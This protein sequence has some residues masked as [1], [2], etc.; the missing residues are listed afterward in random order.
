MSLVTMK[1]LLQHAKENGYAVGSFNM[2]SIETVRGAIRAAEKLNSPIIIQFAQVHTSIVPME[3]IAPVMLEAAR[4]ATVPV[5]VHFDHGTDY[6]EV[7]RA[8]S[9]G[10]TSVMFDAASYPFEKNVSLTKKAVDLAH[11]KGASIE[12]ELGQVGG[13]EG[14]LVVDK[15][16]LTDVKE[17]VEFVERTGVDAL[18]IS[19][20]NL[21]GKYAQPPKL[22]FE[23]LKNVEEA[24]STPL[25]LHGGSG[26]NT[27]DFRKAISLGI[28]KI[29][30][31]TA[32]HADAAEHVKKLVDESPEG[33]GYDVIIEQIIEGISAGVEKHIKIF[34]SDG[35][36]NIK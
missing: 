4:Q 27:E 24:V 6:A 14:D 17:A 28:H 31:A 18:A 21:H 26:T 5:C 34:Q 20:G 23:V 9:L 11:S 3:Y 12:A 8:L 2:L 1:P 35:K 32:I 25:V 7:E 30:V 33:P 22:E 19:I 16:S 10:F 29:N 13:V 36:A 15:G